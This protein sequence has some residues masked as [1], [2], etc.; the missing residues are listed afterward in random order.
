MRAESHDC[1]QTPRIWTGYDGEQ[2]AAYELNTRVVKLLGK[3]EG[4]RNGG[5]PNE[6]PL[7]WF[8]DGSEDLPF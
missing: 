3:R 2:R 1:V 5:V 4:N 6:A 7:E 8:E